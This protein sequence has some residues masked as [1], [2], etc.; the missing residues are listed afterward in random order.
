MTHFQKTC[1]LAPENITPKAPKLKSYVAY[2]GLTKTELHY[3]DQNK[4]TLHKI[5]ISSESQAYQ[6]AEE[7]FEVSEA[8]WT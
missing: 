3:L 7:Q 1:W 5:P 4:N 2:L 8:D 6:I